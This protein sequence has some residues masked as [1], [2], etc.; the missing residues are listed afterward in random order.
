VIDARAIISSDAHIDTAV[1]IGPFSIIEEGVIIGAGTWIG[2]HVVIRR[3]TKIGTSNKI[4]QFASVGEDPQYAG[5]NN[6]E[7]FLEIGNNNI[8]RE[9]CTLNRG[10]PAGTG[11]TQIGHKNLIMAYAHIAHDSVL[12]DNIVFANGASLAGHVQI[13][14]HAIL[15]GFTLVHQFCRIGEYS[16]TGIGSICLQDIPPYVLAAGNPAS[17]RGL[18]IRGLRRHN[19]N[20]DT[21][22]QLK[23][24]YRTIYQKQRPIGD[25]LSDLDHLGRSLKEAASLAAFIRESDRGI[26]RK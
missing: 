8:V 1:T 15:G 3:N 23:K 2:P 11:L 14:N 19:F 20:S 13:G 7:T 25:I 22:Q 4:Y 6:E 12:G 16:M 9:H 24:A 21:I 10:S 17:P 5:Y 18:N 26:I